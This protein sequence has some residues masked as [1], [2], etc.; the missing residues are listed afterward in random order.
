MNSHEPW[1][2]LD[3]WLENGGP[4][5]ESTRLIYAGYVKNHVAGAIGVST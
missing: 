2:M 1:K 4:A 3:A 5:G